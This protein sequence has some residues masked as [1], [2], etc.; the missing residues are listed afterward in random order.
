MR[1]LRSYLD[2][3][4]FK[5]WALTTAAGWAAGLVLG[6]LALVGIVL[7]T[8]VI[9]GTIP[10]VGLAL[11]GALTGACVGYAQQRLLRLDDA[12][13]KR[14]MGASALG[15]AIGIFPAMV[16]SFLTG[17]SSVIGFA[18][19]GAI[20]GAAIGAAQISYR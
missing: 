7:L 20:F 17:I 15:G 10:F 12:Q 6:G 14:W 16:A 11:G 19:V 1:H 4:R 13:S 2:N 18:M 5:Q 3:E 8:L 9:G